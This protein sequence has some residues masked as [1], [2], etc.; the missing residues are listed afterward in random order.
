MDTQRST[1]KKKH[2][3]YSRD[4]FNIAPYQ[5]AKRPQLKY[6]VESKVA[7]KRMRRFFK[8][9]REAKTYVQ[10][11]R[12]ELHNH[13]AEG[14]TF[15][16]EL[17]V[18]AQWAKE[19]LEP[20]GKTIT[21]A[22]EHFLKHLRTERGSVPVRQAVDELIA[23][24][25]A[26][27]LSTVYIGDLRFRLG[28]FSKSFGDR[29]IA[30]ITTKEIVE[31]L[32]SLGVGAVTRNTFRRDIRTLFSFAIEHSYCAENPAASKA[33]LAKEQNNKDVEV[34]SVDQA[35][36]LLLVSSPDMVT[37][38]A[39]GLFAGLRPSEI[40]KLQWS[41]V[42]LNDA[43]ITVRSSKTGRKRFVKIQP[44]LTAWL[45]PYQRDEGN[46]VAPVNFRRSYPADKA[47]AG[48]SDW[49]VNAMRHSFGS[50]H[51][52]QFNDIPAL[53]VQM[54]TSPE[55]IER[56]YRKAVRP[57]EAHQYW[58]LTPDS[59]KGQSKVI[60]AIAAVN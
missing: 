43:L 53:A 45:S 13:G 25:K 47:V 20:F 29:S 9:E 3:N 10:L 52:A 18:M 59:I 12:I 1:A 22:V 30:S 60:A 15:P 17:R 58:A 42:D 21:D 48:L 11:R 40:R 14:M 46:V 31:F 56:H 36:K 35:K 24:R 7:G 44:N 34:L 57:K 4:A 23:N 37:Y 28:R 2:H 6:V 51:V 55:I 50:Y 38:W 5:D 27:G 33:T 19:Q 49:P 41:D 8:T 26:A 54:G 39:I 32:E 16:A